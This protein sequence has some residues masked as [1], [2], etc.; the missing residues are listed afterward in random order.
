LIERDGWKAPEA[1]LDL[2]FFADA[3]D[4]WDAPRCAGWATRRLAWSGVG[5]TEPVA[6]EVAT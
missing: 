6:I 2:I 1:W 5:V 4:G 3:V